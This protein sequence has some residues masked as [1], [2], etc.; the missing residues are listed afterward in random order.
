MVDSPVS[1][2]AAAELPPSPARP[3]QTTTLIVDLE[4]AGEGLLVEVA[5]VPA[6]SSLLRTRI[7]RSHDTGR[8]LWEVDSRSSIIEVAGA[9]LASGPAGPCRVIASVSG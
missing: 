8:D 9:L 5:K 1:E 7:Y 6:S 2:A 3:G 4:L